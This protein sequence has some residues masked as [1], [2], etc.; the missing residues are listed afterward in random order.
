MAFKGIIKRRH[1]SMQDILTQAV[2]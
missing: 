1:N 2:Y